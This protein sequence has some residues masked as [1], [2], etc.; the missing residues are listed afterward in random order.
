[1]RFI[2]CFNG[3]I[4]CK[5]DCGTGITGFITKG[6]VIGGRVGLILF[7]FG[8]W[9]AM[10]DIIEYFMTIWIN[11]RERL[12]GFA[13]DLYYLSQAKVCETLCPSEKV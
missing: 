7:N 12:Y 11:S 5:W 13:H 4:L 6:G 3:G 1:M 2:S 9:Y 10:L 8:G